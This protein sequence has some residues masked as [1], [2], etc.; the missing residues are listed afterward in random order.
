MTTDNP[1]PAP[2][3]VL[4]W[5]VVDAKGKVRHVD[6]YA[7]RANS[8]SW[9]GDTVV[10]LGRLA[11]R[12]TPMRDDVH[13]DTVRLD[14]LEAIAQKWW[15]GTIGRPTTWSVRF[16]GEGTFREAIDAHPSPDAATTDHHTT[17]DAE[18]ALEE[19]RKLHDEG[20]AM[21]GKRMQKYFRHEDDADDHP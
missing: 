20:N 15:D 3:D 16:Q 10:P 4:A 19:Q 9:P 1:V 18:R 6:L 11:A 17:R 8:A 7:A 13:P 5:A 2:G 21:I 14:K 12:P